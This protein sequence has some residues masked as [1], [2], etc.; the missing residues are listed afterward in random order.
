[1]TFLPGVMPPA[2]SPSMPAGSRPTGSTQA[3]SEPDALDRES[4]ATSAS[5]RLARSVG[6]RGLSVAEA[7]A[8]LRADGLTD[9]E[10]ADIV[11]GFVQRGWLDDAALA[12]QLVYAAT[13]RKDMGT[14]AV[15]QLLVKRLVSREVIDAVIAEL[16][17]DDAERALEFARAKARALTRY[18]DDTATRRLMGMLARRGFGGAAAGQAARTALAEERRQAGGS[19][20]RFR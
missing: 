18:D 3:E 14:R 20:V 11:D 10:A 17:D 19:G 7:R 6:R 8:K 12:E 15:R 1:M 2:A 13:T 9:E 16:P 4:L 5:A